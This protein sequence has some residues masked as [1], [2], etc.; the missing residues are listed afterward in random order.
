MRTFLRGLASVMAL[1]VSV[2]V[3][4]A[5]TSASSQTRTDSKPKPVT[6]PPD[7]VAAQSF[8]FAAYPE[9][10]GR[11]LLMH[12]KPENGQVLIAISEAESP[13]ASVEA[14]TPPL[15][16]GSIAFDAKG[17]LQRYAAHG[18]LLDDTRNKLLLQQAAA[19]PEWGE[20]D[21]DAWLTAAG[22]RTTVTG[23]A[24]SEVQ[25]SMARPW[26]SA[27][28]ANMV[29]GPATFQLKARSD[30]KSAPNVPTTGVPG[31][32]VPATATAADGSTLQYVLE[33]EP[34]GGRLVAVTRR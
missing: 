3:A 11:A 15:I 22:G 30:Q 21:L 33:Y 8:V 6:M 9:L 2:P 28:G 24:P 18:A 25:A 12:L 34:F 26:K 29:T 7:I 13:A 14:V 4:H 17:Q 19:H 32:T 5:Q 20:S 10:A 16:V 1:T 27:L 31:W 23:V